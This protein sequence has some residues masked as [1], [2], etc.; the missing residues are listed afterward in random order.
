MFKFIDRTFNPLVA[1]ILKMSIFAVGFGALFIFA[2]VCLG[3]KVES[4]NAMA[5]VIGGCA[6]YVLLYGGV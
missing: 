5:S 1:W 2:L 6:I 3:V 4:F